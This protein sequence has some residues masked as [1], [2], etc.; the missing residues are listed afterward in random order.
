MLENIGHFLDREIQ[1]NF[2][3]FKSQGFENIEISP[4]IADN[5]RV[6]SIL[7]EA[8]KK[9][10]GGYVIAGLMGHGDA[11]VVRDPWGIRPAFYLCQ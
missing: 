5:L 6:D 8:S 3:A 7:R 1:R 2:D 11:F 10:D 4:L 9:W